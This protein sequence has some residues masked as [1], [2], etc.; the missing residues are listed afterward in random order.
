[1]V[2]RKALATVGLAT[3]PN[4]GAGNPNTPVVT[5]DAPTF[6]PPAGTYTSAQSVTISTTTTGAILCYT[7]DGS[8]PSCDSTPTCASGALY[9][10]PVSISTTTTLK[11]LAC[12]AGNQ[13]SAVGTG[14]YVI[15]SGIIGLVYS[16][17]AYTFQENIAIATI[18]PTVTETVT[19]CSAIPTLPTGLSINNTTCAISGTPTT[20]QAATAYTITA[21]KA[22]RKHDCVH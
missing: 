20:S 15:G 12:K 11:A 17:S 22:K 1:M 6:S 10:S 5:I 7:T 19:S 18:T 14:D 2:L 8:T 3:E 4:A 13:Y 9:S 21:S 16:S